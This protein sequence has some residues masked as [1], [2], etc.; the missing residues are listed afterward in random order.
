[1]EKGPSVHNLKTH[2]RLKSKE[3]F[4]LY[5]KISQIL[6][7]RELLERVENDNKPIRTVKFIATVEDVIEM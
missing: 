7:L 2:S 4:P 1:M 5:I 6:P 3:L